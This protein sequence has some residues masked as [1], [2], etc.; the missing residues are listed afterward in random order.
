MSERADRLPAQLQR[1]PWL[2]LLVPAAI[3]FAILIG[4]G[5]WQLQRKAWKEALIASLTVRLAAPPAAL[6]APDTWAD[7]DPSRDEYRPVTLTATFD[8]PAEALVYAG[9]SALRPDVSGAGYWV[10]AP[11]HLAGGATVVVNRGF[12]PEGR[13]E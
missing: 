12:V 1:R 13:Q 6:P 9:G 3:V 10:F 4:L 5:T 2:G 11:A 7:L 8:Y